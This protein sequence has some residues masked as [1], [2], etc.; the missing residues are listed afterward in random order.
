MASN[1]GD[2]SEDARDAKEKDDE[3]GEISED[4]FFTLDNTPATLNDLDIPTYNQNYTNVL[5]A[6]DEEEGT[7]SNSKGSAGPGLSVCFNCS[8]NHVLS[9]CPMPKDHVAI[10]KNRRLYMAKRNAGSTPKSNVRYHL[11]EEQRFAH[12]T[13]GKLSHELY[14]ALGLEEDELPLHIYKMRQ[15]GYPPGWLEHARV[16][17]SGISLF[18]STGEEVAHPEDEEG[19][20]IA[21]GSR[22][23][24]DSN[25]IIEFPGF[26]VPCDPK[27]VDCHARYNMPPIK[28]E[29]SKEV[30]LSQLQHTK[31]YKRMRKFGPP[32]SRS[33]CLAGSSS[34]ASSSPANATLIPADMEVEDVSDEPTLLS[35]VE[36]DGCRFIPPLPRETP[37]KAPPP[38]PPL[39]EE[40][41]L[42]PPGEDSEAEGQGASSQSSSRAQSPSLSD[43]EAQKSQLLAALEDGGSSSGD[44]SRLL[45]KAVGGPPDDSAPPDDP[46]L[47]DGSTSSTAAPVTPG[48]VKSVVL[49]TPALFGASPYTCLPSPAAF[50]RDI[51]DVINF[52]NLPDSTGKY[53]KMSDL[54]KKVRKVVAKLQKE[55][56]EVA[57]PAGSP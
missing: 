21:E 43:L 52:E 31:S 1:N 28:W 8:G 50:S 54:I 22:D 26:N 53:E 45:G 38:P 10:G 37:P 41:E 56:E 7:L 5:K 27:V 55:G 6:K 15:Y 30:M 13:P 2:N 19:E 17:H 14:E 25:K 16:S 36:D 24:Y 32:A 39:E 29:Q 4:F 9:D 46:S 49:G 57:S 48:M 51:C 12:L 11:D 42:R 44:T 18:G 34:S 20:I 40:C 3:E 35:L 33:P 47:D 23:K